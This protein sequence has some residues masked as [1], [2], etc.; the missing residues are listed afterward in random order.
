MKYLLLITISVFMICL[1]LDLYG[2]HKDRTELLCLPQKEV[3]I[4]LIDKKGYNRYIKLDISSQ[5]EFVMDRGTLYVKYKRL[6][7]P[8]GRGKD[9]RI[10]LIKDK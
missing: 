10:L 7:K 8:I 1:G 5:S 9:Y 2:L 3:H 6:S 4:A